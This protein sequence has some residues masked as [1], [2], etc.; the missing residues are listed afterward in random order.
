MSIRELVALGTSSQVP[1]RYRN[2][3]GYLLR[4]DGVGFLFDPGEGTQ[5]QFILA[6]IGVPEVRRIFVTHFHGDHALGLAGIV[7]RLSLDRVPAPVEVF[8]PRSGQVFFERLVKAT[9][10]HSAVELV[11]RPVAGKGG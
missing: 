8:F 5:R 1:T 2:H 9:I 7:Q 11:P 6:D 3:N 10:Y 4:W